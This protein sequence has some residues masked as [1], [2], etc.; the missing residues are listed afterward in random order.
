M[1]SSIA[2]FSASKETICKWVTSFH[3][4]K[5]PR[6]IASGV[7]NGSYNLGQ[8]FAFDDGTIW[9]LRLPRA[10]NILPEY[11]DENVAMEVEALHLVREKTSIPVPEIYAWGFA[12]ENEPELGPFILMSFIDGVCRRDVIGSDDGSRL[13][14]ESVPDSDVKYIHRKMADCMLQL[15]KIDFDQIGNLPTSITRFNAPSRPLT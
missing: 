10:R 9:F 1:K 15:F 6:Q 7:L 5:L 4:K 14:R 12:G 2:P 3:P 13:L 11:A 8:K